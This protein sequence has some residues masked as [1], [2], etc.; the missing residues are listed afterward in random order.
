MPTG[1]APVTIV[2]RD[3]TP[4]AGSSASSPSFEQSIGSGSFAT[5]QAPSSVSPANALLIVAARAGRRSVT[6]TNITGTQ[7]VFFVN[8]ANAT[9]ATT[10]FFI[11]GTA[12][13]SVTIPTS[14]AVYA[15]SP[16]AAQTIA[17][18]ETY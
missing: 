7:P 5:T 8:A 6:L 17:V 4:A 18:V 10:G 9:G 1:G 16:T 15:T 11:A 2:N 3:G 12:G 13:A 14:A